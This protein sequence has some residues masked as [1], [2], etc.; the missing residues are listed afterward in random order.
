MRSEKRLGL[1]VRFGR[2]NVDEAAA[3]EAER[4]PGRDELGKD[5]AFE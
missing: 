5:L 1:G 3:R 4:H 2:T